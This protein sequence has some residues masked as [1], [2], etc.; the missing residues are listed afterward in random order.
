MNN[1]TLEN[2]SNIPSRRGFLGA[3]VSLGAITG[4]SYFFG[5]CKDPEYTDLRERLEGTDKNGY[6]VDDSKE[7]VPSLD[8]FKKA[9]GSRYDP[10]RDEELRNFWDREILKETDASEIAGYFIDIYKEPQETK[11]KITNNELKARFDNSYLTSV[12]FSKL[13]NVQKEI[14]WRVL[15]PNYEMISDLPE[16]FKFSESDEIMLNMWLA[17]REGSIPLSV[18]YN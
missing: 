11:R 1:K 2:I 13:Q 18:N 9:L 8:D 3:I 6:F 14:P 17:L 12:P 15:P 10:R 4:S 5:G 7:N 16:G